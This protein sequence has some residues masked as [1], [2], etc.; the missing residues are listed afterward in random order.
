MTPNKLLL[1]ICLFFSL[2]HLECDAQT[3]SRAEKYRTIDRCRI[4]CVY[5]HYVYDP[6]LDRSQIEDELLEIGHTKSRYCIYARYQRDSVMAKD[7]PNGLP[8]EEYSKLGDKFGRMSLDEMIKDRAKNTITSFEHILMDHYIFEEPT[9][10][11]NWSLS[12]ETEEICKYNCKKRPHHSEGAT[13]LL[14]IPKKY[15]LQTGRGN[16]VAYPD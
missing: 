9:P 6:V 3:R 12:D 8:F 2:F 7:Y 14:G 1:Y 15:P 10:D 5:E 4:Q 11:F 16:S 13:G